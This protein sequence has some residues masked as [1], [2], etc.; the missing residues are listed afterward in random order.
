MEG[1]LPKRS[2]GRIK[3]GRFAI[4]HQKQW[5]SPSYCDRRIAIGA[6]ADQTFS[7]L[8]TINSQLGSNDVRNLGF[9]FGLGGGNKPPFPAR[10][11]GSY[12]APMS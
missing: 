7:Q 6:L 4:A 10:R 1:I 3:E 8:S 12:G 5:R 2:F 9:A 11:E